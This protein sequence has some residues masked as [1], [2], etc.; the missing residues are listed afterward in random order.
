MSVIKFEL[1]EEHLKLLKHLKWGLL[2][3]KFLVSSEN[4][5]ED[6]A[7]FGVDDVYEGIDL[8]LNGKPENFNP[9][10]TYEFNNYSEDQKKEWDK[11]LSELPTALD[12]ILYNGHFELGL[13]KTRYHDRLWKKI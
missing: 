5:S 10:E 13:Y 3:N 2:D 9:L 6:T 4:I 7:P 1:K 11:L 8:I 12:I